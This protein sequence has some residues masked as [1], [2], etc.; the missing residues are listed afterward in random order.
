[1]ALI[2]ED[3]TGLPN[4]DSYQSL[5]EADIYAAN[6]GL[7]AWSALAASPGVD[8]AQK[9]VAL[10]NATL[11]IDISREYVSQKLN[12]DQAL[13][14]PRLDPSVGMPQKVRDCA[15]VLAD[16][17]VQGV[18]LNEVSEIIKEISVGVGRS[19]VVESKKYDT[20]LVVSSTQKAYNLIKD[21]VTSGPN[22]GVSEACIERS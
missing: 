16:L 14:F 6:F 21:Y 17:F 11:N 9:E 5:T 15:V 4:A 10:R 3:G 18:D 20:P 2:V 22:D 19:A 8:D 1:M 12:D 13:E 7:T